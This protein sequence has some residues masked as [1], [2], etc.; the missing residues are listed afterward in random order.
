[1]SKSFHSRKDFQ[2]HQINAHN[3]GIIFLC[4]CGYIATG[5]KRKDAH[6]NNRKEK[7]YKINELKA[8]IE[9]QGNA[10]Y[11][12]CHKEPIEILTKHAEKYLQAASKYLISLNFLKKILI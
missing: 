2:Q 11:V 12:F 4:G 1:V 10:E 5:P 7:F 6:W 9:E 3:Q 8:T